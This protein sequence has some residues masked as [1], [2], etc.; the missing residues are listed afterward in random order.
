MP[1]YAFKC[2]S[3]NHEGDV[4]VPWKVYVANNGT[5][6]CPKC[7]G[8]FKRDWS[9]IGSAPNLKTE[10]RLED[11]WNKAGLVQPGDPEYEKLNRERV[12][13]MRSK[14]KKRRERLLDQGKA[15]LR[16]INYVDDDDRPMTREVFEEMPSH[17]KSS[18]HVKN[19]GTITED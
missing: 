10:E 6:Q 5:F 2:E 14:D 7:Q 4:T 9:A 15:R 11:L 13:E 17:A 1:C 3:C 12:K 18:Y 19:D 16:K 8:A